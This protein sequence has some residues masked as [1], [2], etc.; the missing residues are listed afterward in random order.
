MKLDYARVST[1]DQHLEI[2]CSRLLQ[3]GREMLFEEK[4]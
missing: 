2:Q 3:A 1:E 4:K